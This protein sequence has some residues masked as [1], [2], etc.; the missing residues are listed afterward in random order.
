MTP[1]IRTQF[2]LIARKYIP[3]I[4]DAQV[5]QLAQYSDLLMEWNEKINLV[6]RRDQENIWKH[7]IIGSILFLAQ[8]Q[9]ESPFTMLD[10]GTG[11][12]LPGIALAILFPESR[13]TLID[14]IQKKIM[15][16]SDIIERLGLKNAR[17]ICIRAEDLARDT[18]EAKKYDYAMAR[19]VAPIFDIIKWGKPFIKPPGGA[20][21]TE[22]VKII[23]RGNIIMLKG[24][25]LTAEKES[26][27]IKFK[28]RKILD[29][30]LQFI[31]EIPE[32]TD[33]KVIVVSA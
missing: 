8:Y 19:A 13:F 5:A 7:H 6:S 30:P 2:D 17:A 29:L 24:G 11:G 20:I 23:P 18:K 21:P 26:A 4:T 27:E 1:E 9:L 14:S 3:N 31:V 12:G 10:I 16:V 22:P 25:D 28:P 33:K 15:V 32:I